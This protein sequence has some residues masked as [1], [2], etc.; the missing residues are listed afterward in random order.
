MFKILMDLDLLRTYINLI[1][2]SLFPKAGVTQSLFHTG[3]YKVVTILAIYNCMDFFGRYIVLAFKQTKRKTY[4]ISLGRTILVFLLIF[5]YYCEKDLGV[6]LTVTSILL[7]IYI[8]ALGLTH[9]MG[10]SLCFGLAP[11]MVKDDLKLQAGSSMSFFTVFGLFLG[12]CLAFLT[13]YI[14]EKIEE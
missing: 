4:I 3:K 9:G 7:I 5:N 10:N 12:S 11:T 13:K 1:S 2:N 8:V 6:D 14:L